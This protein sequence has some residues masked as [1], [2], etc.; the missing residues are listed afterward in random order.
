MKDEKTEILELTKKE[1]RDAKK[2]KLLA[3]HFP[4]IKPLYHSKPPTIAERV[5]KW[6]TKH[7]S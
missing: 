1:L 3:S 7:L 2:A 4:A 5:D 6:L